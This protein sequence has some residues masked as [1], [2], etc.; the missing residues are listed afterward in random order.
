MRGVQSR[1]LR[2]AVCGPVFIVAVQAQKFAWRQPRLALRAQRQEGRLN[3]RSDQA[4]LQGTNEDGPNAPELAA[5]IGH[6]R[7]GEALEA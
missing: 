2:A 7:Q 5:P 3:S 6:G 4:H 1:N